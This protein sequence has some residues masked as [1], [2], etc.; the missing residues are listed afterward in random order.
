VTIFFLLFSL[1]ARS[2]SLGLQQIGNLGG[3]IQSGIGP[4][5]SHSMGATVAS[6]IGQGS[7]R[8]DQG[9]FVPCDLK[10]TS[11]SDRIEDALYHNPLIL[12]YPNPTSEKLYFEGAIEQIGRYELFSPTG[13]RISQGHVSKQQLSL[14]PLPDGIYFLHLFSKQ[15]RLSFVGKVVKQE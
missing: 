10:C 7:I 5:L 9:M 14:D 8:L 3:E 1:H 2:Q 12:V 15:G 6:S 13:Q 11:S 4:A